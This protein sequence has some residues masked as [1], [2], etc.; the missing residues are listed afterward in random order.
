MINMSE[1]DR[2][3]LQACRLFLEND[4]GAVEAYLAVGG[5]PMRQITA[6]DAKRLERY[7]AFEPGHTLVHLAIHNHRE[8][9]LPLL[10][11]YAESSM[12]NIGSNS[13][14]SESVYYLV[15][16]V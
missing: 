16:L 11:S 6:E 14:Q 10:L 13:F 1:T 7:G 9:I 15:P 2:L 5:D 3:W 4:T 8:D 12:K